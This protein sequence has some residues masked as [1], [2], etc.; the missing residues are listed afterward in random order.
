MAP[1]QFEGIISK[2][3]DQYALGCIAYELFTGR[4]PFTATSLE[5]MWYKHAKE[6]PV[7]PMQLNSHLPI[8]IEQAILKAMA[9]QRH[10]RYT[11]ISDFIT[12]LRMS[13]IIEM[14]VSTTPQTS[15]PTTPSAGMPMLAQTVT[16][17]PGLMQK[18]K[19][20]ILYEGDIHYGAKRYAEALSA[21]ELAIQ[22]DPVYAKSY[23]NKGNALYRLK[24]H[25]EALAAYEQA[26]T[27]DPSS[28]P[29][30]NGK[31]N[32]LYSENKL[33]DALAAYE[34]TLLLSPHFSTA[35]YN[36]SLILYQLDQYEDALQAVEE[37]IRLRP[38]D[39]DYWIRK[40]QIL[41]RLHRRD[42]AR[43]AEAE[44]KRLQGR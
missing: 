44:A 43:L 37:A 2:Q 35:W 1:E 23:R 34:H 20:Q 24:R 10:E 4:K 27:I 17:A 6:D 32:V 29:A 11:D 30:W 22:L 19:E 25:E 7:A 38:G 21:Y 39:P 3:S 9:K 42:D 15:L 16:P 40:A 13:S 14:K 18:T 26:L 41:R 12:A 33:R 8:H 31:G 5:I 28:S 36:K